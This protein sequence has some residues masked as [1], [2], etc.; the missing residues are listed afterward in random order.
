[1]NSEKMK[2]ERRV[3]ATDSGMRLDAFWARELDEI[4]VS[5]GKVQEWIK[6]GG[7]SVDMLLVTKAKYKIGVGEVL[8]LKGEVASCTVNPEDLPL[9]ILFEDE[10]IAVVCKPAGLTTH[11]APSQTEGTLVNRLLARY[12]EICAM[13]P[14]RPGIVHRLDKDTSGVMVVAR[15]EKARLKLA[16]DFAERRVD[17]LYL[18]LAHGV[19]RDTDTDINLPLGRHPRM[20][21]RMAVVE[22][23]GR[24]AKTKVKVLW[25]DRERTMSFLAVRILTGR[26]HQVR[27]HLASLDHALL[28]DVNYGPRKH[29]AWQREGG[30]A[31]DLCVRQMLHA[32]CLSFDHPETGERL[33][34]FQSPPEDFMHLLFACDTHSQR[35]GIT[36]AAGSGKSSLLRALAA[37]GA[38]TFSADICVAELYAPG[39]DGSEMI[40]SRF[41]GR[42]TSPEGGVDKVALFEAMRD[43]DGVRREI[44]DVIHPI[45][46]HRM[47]AFFLEHRDAPASFAEIP[48][49][50]ESGWQEEDPLDLLVG[51]DCPEARRTGELRKLRGLDPEALALFDSWQWPAEKKIAACDVVVTNNG[52]L[53]DLETE[54]RMLL[55]RTQAMHRERTA[56]F[57]AYVEDILSTLATAPTA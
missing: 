24:P 14:V 48:L 30:P 6:A 45:V 26:T 27:V 25:H 46:R 43:S 53:A 17:K 34:F 52:T 13:D 36:G 15:T 49:L 35:V 37:Q 44:M 16:E 54:A 10:H 56:E 1:M 23:G 12:P 29:G 32:Y 19:P 57:E 51:V 20:K 55:E 21:T 4:G 9:D 18:A 3:E 38:P 5:R 8:N 2:W 50:L 22:K 31:A 11:P 40:A 33:T 41:G 47:Q 7:A 42:Y 39:G 28:G